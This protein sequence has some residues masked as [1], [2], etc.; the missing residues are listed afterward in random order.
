MMNHIKAGYWVSRRQ[1]RK[2]QRDYILRQ[3]AKWVL[4]IALIVGA[5]WLF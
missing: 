1:Q 4:P 2:A 5:L 3:Y